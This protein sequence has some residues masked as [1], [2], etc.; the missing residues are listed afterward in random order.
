MGNTATLFG[1]YY[2]I[3]V[4]KYLSWSTPLSLSLSLSLS[5]FFDNT[6]LHVWSLILSAAVVVLK[7]SRNG[8]AQSSASTKNCDWQSAS[9]WTSSFSEAVFKFTSLQN[10]RSLLSVPWRTFSVSSRSWTFDV[11]NELLVKL[12]SR[13]FLFLIFSSLQW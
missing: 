13:H 7:L 6:N 9:D 4:D 11:H 12:S 8:L 3:P 1:N 5:L 2:W 10:S